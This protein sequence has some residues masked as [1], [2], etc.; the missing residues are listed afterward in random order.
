MTRKP[1]AP[2]WII[3]PHDGSVWNLPELRDE[4]FANLSASIEWH[5]WN[6]TADADY[7]S[8][9]EAIDDVLAAADRV[10]EVGDSASNPHLPGDPFDYYITDRDGFP[11]TG[12]ALP[13]DVVWRRIYR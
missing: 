5:D 7:A 6:D 12:T 13:T 9:E 4:L 8:G 10:E 3:A 1:P 2:D 11:R